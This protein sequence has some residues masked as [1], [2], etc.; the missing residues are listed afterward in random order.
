L[1]IL[2]GLEIDAED[3]NS[4]LNELKNDSYCLIIRGKSS[5]LAAIEPMLSGI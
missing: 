4:Y 5:V 1:G 2:K 3:I